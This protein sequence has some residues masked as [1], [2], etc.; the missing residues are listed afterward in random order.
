MGSGLEQG[1]SLGQRP[2]ENHW[3]APHARASVLGRYTLMQVYNGAFNSGQLKSRGSRGHVTCSSKAVGKRR[4]QSG[5]E[6]E[7]KAK[8]TSIF[9]GIVSIT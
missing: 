6:D 9:L 8:G 3:M 4:L 2:G 7:S 5:E 1:R